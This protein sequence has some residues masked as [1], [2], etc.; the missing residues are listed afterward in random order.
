MLKLN[1]K[2]LSF[3]IIK[4]KYAQ[5]N[6]ILDQY[7]NY[8]ALKK[9]EIININN[10][11]CNNKFSDSSIILPIVSTKKQEIIFK[12]KFERSKQMDDNQNMNN[13]NMIGKMLIKTN[14]TKFHFNFDWEKTMIILHQ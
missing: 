14:L 2:P 5:Y 1:W 10:E 4:D 8:P 9:N 3:F 13:M 12:I 11:K 7:K 6:E